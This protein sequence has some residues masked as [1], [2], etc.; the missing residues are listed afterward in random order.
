MSLRTRHAVISLLGIAIAITLLLA[1]PEIDR[2]RAKAIAGVP[3]ADLRAGTTQLFAVPLPSPTPVGKPG[4]ALPTEGI[5]LNRTNYA[6]ASH[7]A[8]ASALS[9]AAGY[10]PK[11][12]ID[13]DRKG[14][15]FGKDGYWNSKDATFPQW[16]E[17]H[18]YGDKTITEIDVF[19]IQDNY[20]SPAEPTP[21]MEFTAYG[22]TDFDVEFWVE[23][24]SVPI[25]LGGS[26]GYWVA[27]S[28]A[29]RRGNKLVWNQFD[30]SKSPITTSRI[31]VKCLGSIDMQSRIAEVEAW[32][33]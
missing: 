6:L 21:T 18:F 1:F 29:S 12:A 24:Q 32:G 31:R 7:K 13:G 3:A 19:T 22:L 25:P 14:L 23:G 28:G 10:D 27:I 20:A 5:I 33:K 26:K 8:Y 4:V 17:V 16:L 9:A 11:G 15:N 30:F 2:S